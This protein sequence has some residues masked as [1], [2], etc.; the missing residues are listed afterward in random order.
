MP[1]GRDDVYW[2]NKDVWFWKRH[3]KTVLQT[4]DGFSFIL[5]VCLLLVDF[6]VSVNSACTQFFFNTKQLVVF[7][8]TV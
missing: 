1:V 8:H 7:C 3:K 2:I 5:K 6:F 4:K